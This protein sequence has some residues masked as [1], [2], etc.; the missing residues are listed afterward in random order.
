MSRPASA[1][2]NKVTQLPDLVPQLDSFAFH[3]PYDVFCQKSHFEYTRYG[4]DYSGRKMEALVR[5]VERKYGWIDEEELGNVV[6]EATRY[7]LLQS[8]Q[9]RPRK[10]RQHLSKRGALNLRNDRRKPVLFPRRARFGNLSRYCSYSG[11]AYDRV[12]T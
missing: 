11:Y 7:P 10:S 3:L 8:P 1:A 4:Q 12:G 2:S 6:G 5:E 9:V